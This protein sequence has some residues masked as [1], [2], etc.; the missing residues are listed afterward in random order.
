[1]N[2]NVTTMKHSITFERPTTYED[3][4]EE[5]VDS[6]GWLAQFLMQEWG[7]YISVSN[8]VC[9]DD[10]GSKTERADLCLQREEVQQLIEFLQREL[11]AERNDAA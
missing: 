3:H 11:T 10:G 5:I 7:L 6:Y 8:E 2:T 1:M 4:D 9:D